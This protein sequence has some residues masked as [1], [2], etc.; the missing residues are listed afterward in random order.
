MGTPPQ[1]GGTVC[2]KSRPCNSPGAKSRHFLPSFLRN[3]RPCVIRAAHQRAGLDVA[4]SSQQCLAAQ[5]GKLLWRDVT[6]DGKMLRRR[7]EI[8]PQREDVT[9]NIT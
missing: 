6:L 2:E 3:V 8:L 5:V 1:N 4:K 9:G 7:P